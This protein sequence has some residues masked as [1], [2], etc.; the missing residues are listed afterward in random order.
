MNDIIEENTKK[1]SKEEPVDETLNEIRE[2]LIRPII[3]AFPHDNKNPDFTVMDWISNIWNIHR[4]PIFKFTVKQLFY[5]PGNHTVDSFKDVG[6]PTKLKMPIK[7]STMYVRFND[8]SKEDFTVD[9]EVLLPRICTYVMFNMS[10]NDF[11]EIL[12]YLKP[13]D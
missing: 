1:V 9:V 6:I 3:E 12:K 10:M 11:S 8:T 7:G 13:I 5:I 2:E 4:Y